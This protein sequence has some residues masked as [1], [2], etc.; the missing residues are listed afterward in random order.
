[1]I[2]ALDGLLGCTVSLADLDED[3]LQAD[4]C[5]LSSGELERLRRI[6]DPVQR[7]RRARCRAA[8]RS[9]LGEALGVPA[10]RVPLAT[11]PG[12]KPYVVGARGLSFSVSHSGA[13]GAIAVATEGP[14][15]VDIE[16]AGSRRNVARLARRWFS[17]AEIAALERL[18]PDLR[19][20]SFLRC[21]TAKEAV[22]KA[23]GE[24]LS[25]LIRRVIV[26][27]DPRR[28]PRIL[29]GPHAAG[30]WTL[31]EPGIPASFGGDTVVTVAVGS[32]SL[33][34]G[35]RTAGTSRVSQEPASSSR[36]ARAEN[37]WLTPP[38]LRAPP[39]S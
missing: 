14:V 21:W 9:I 31:S 24:P 12:G 5:A 37:R 20:R 32:A 16:V 33:G 17:S 13:V 7:A 39:R 1:M 25:E 15:G 29:G 2:T 30:T 6:V 4:L 36:K 34:E 27:P 38:T 22:A 10:K 26:D 3:S 18:P 11:D 19:A 8:L 28:P 23:V 35:S